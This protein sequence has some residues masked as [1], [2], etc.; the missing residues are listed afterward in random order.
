MALN[1]CTLR[2]AAKECS[3]KG[4]PSSRSGNARGP[5]AHPKNLGRL[6]FA[7]MSLQ[8]LLQ[9]ARFCHKN[10]VAFDAQKLLVTK[11][12]ER[13]RQRFARCSHFCGKHTLGSV[14]F[15]L[16]LRRADGPWALL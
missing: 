4:I 11:F 2:S 9:F 3:R 12:C 5:F 13:T 1:P 15:N 8:Q 10:I 16:N 6:Q 7:E 14:E